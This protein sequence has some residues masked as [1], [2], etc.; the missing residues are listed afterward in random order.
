M[1][2]SERCP[3]E[4]ATELVLFVTGD[5]PRSRRARANLHSALAQSGLEG[6]SCREIDLLRE[7]EQALVHGTFATPALAHMRDGRLQGVL[8]GDLSERDRLGGF[9][10]ERAAMAPD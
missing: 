4:T 5:A 7:P 8:Y 9:L 10:R 6:L 1:T 3:Q 2:D